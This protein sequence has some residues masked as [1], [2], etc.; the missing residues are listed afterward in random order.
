MYVQEQ[1]QKTQHEDTRPYLRCEELCLAPYNIGECKVNIEGKVIQTRTN[2]CL[3]S[4]LESLLNVLHGDE[5]C[6]AYGVKAGESSPH[7][8][9]GDDGLVATWTSDEDWRE[10]DSPKVLHRSGF[11]DTGGELGNWH[12]LVNRWVLLRVVRADWFDLL[13]S[14]LVWQFG[15]CLTSDFGISVSF[16]S[17]CVWQ[18]AQMPDTYYEFNASKWS[19][20]SRK[21][22]NPWKRWPILPSRFRIWS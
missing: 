7:A 11:I 17:S 3:K 8:I 21:K 2:I 4:E 9:S 15:R 1:T 10:T 16:E 5:G 18:F 22:P 20:G 19:H 6:T 13:G 12:S 14:R